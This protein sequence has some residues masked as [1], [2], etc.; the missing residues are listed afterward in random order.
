MSCPLNRNRFKGSG[1]VKQCAESPG[2]AELEARMKEMMSVRAAQ[3]VG[4]FKP[5][6]GLKT[7]AAPT[8]ATQT[9]IAPS[10]KDANF[11]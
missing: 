1:Y 10:F 6:E 2:A 8:T 5:T 7:A 11:H 4:V 9:K 3:D